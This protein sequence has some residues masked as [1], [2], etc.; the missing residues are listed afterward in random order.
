MSGRAAEIAPRAS[1]GNAVSYY[2]LA[3]PKPQPKRKVKSR[4]LR[5]HTPMKKINKRRG[6]HAFPR[7]VDT[8]YR[9]W[10]RGLACILAPRYPLHRCVGAAQVC[11]VKSRGA[12]GPDRA[13]IVPM[14]ASAHND[15]HSVGIRSFEKFWGISLRTIA[16]QLTEVYEAEKFPCP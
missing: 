5:Q 2:T 9:D 15:Q 11:H 16:R 13:N 4:G 14:C 3:V 8:A 6:G 12:G 1:S 10:I 7:N